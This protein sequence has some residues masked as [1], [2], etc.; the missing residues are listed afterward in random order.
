[1]GLA[2]VD[3]GDAL[4]VIE[5]EGLGTRVPTLGL[6]AEVHAGVEQVFG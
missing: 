1:V 3:D 6:V 4:A 2:Q 5:D